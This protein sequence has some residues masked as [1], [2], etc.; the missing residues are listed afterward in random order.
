[1]IDR[2]CLAYARLASCVPVRKG[3]LTSSP[4]GW[5]RFQPRRRRK[6]Q[7]LRFA[8]RPPAERRASP[9]SHRMS[10]GEVSGRV[11]VS[12]AGVFADTAAEQRL[13]LT[14]VGC[15]V[16]ACR[17]QLAGEGGWNLL[18]PTAGLVL[19][20]AAKQPPAGLQDPPIESSF[21]PDVAA[22]ALEAAPGRAGHARDA[23]VLN[24]DDVEPASQAGRGLV[25]PVLA[26]AVGTAR[27][28]RNRTH[29][30]FGTQ[31]SP[32]LR[33]RR[34]MWPGLTATIRNASCCRALRQVGLPCVPE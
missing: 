22:R 20:A 16:P 10:C 33:D 2:P 28:Q 11:H 18:D 31:T 8:V 17:A 30:A 34:R 1:M 29:P 14:A 19:Q 25:Y 24:T 6:E 7:G 13:A 23:Q 32:I 5:R 4:H 9:R 15:Y 21:L 27:D 12:V 26:P 3:T